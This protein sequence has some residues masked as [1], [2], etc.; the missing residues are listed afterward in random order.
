[1]ASALSGLIAWWLTKRAYEREIERLSGTTARR[2]RTILR[3]W[4]GDEG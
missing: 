4:R 3:E 2:I 1:M